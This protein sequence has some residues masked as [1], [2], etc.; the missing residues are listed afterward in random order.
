MASGLGAIIL[1]LILVKFD[2]G[3]STPE[4]DL[5]QADLQRLEQQDESLKR[6]LNQRDRDALAEA[7]KM[8]TVQ[9][10]IRTLKREIS[11]KS[12][13]LKQQQVVMSSVKNSIKNAPRAKKDDVVESGSGGEEDYIMGLKVEGRKILY[14]IDSSASMTDE[15]LIE[16]IR[17]KNSSDAEKK[18]G[19]KWQRTKRI[20]Q[21]LLARSPQSSQVAVVAFNKQVKV[22]GGSGWFNARDASAIGQVQRELDQFVPT[23]ATNLQLGLQKAASL[24]PTDIYL[25]TDG[26]PT[27]GESRYSSLNPFAACSSLLGRSNNISGLCRVKLFRQTVAESAPGRDTK[28]NVVLLPIEGD[29]QAAPEFWRWSAATGGLLITPAVSWP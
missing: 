3:Q 6:S 15:K 16:I 25:V 8:A 22:L 21:W 4:A 10:E 27:A 28:V 19:P 13:A 20:V 2:V 5:L 29:P 9:A 11:Q 7:A 18:R 26:L 24:N 1:V 23:G 12:D 17:R 14:L